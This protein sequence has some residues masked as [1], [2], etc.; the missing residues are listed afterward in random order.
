MTA[1]LHVV[2]AIANTKGGVGKTTT[3]VNLAA[4]LAAP[5]RRVLLVDLDSQG[6]ASLSCGVPRSRLRPSSAN[7][8]LNDLPP[9]QAIRPTAVPHLD[10]ITGSIELANADLVLSEVKGREQT[11]KHVLKGPRAKYD[12]VILD[13]PPNLS[14][15]GINAMVAADGVIVPVA[16]QYLA[17]EGLVTLLTA[18]EKVRT[19]LST[20]NRVLGIL[21]NLVD[22]ASKDQAE[23]RN[24]LRAQY[25]DRVFHTEIAATPALS[26]A[27]GNGHTIFAHAPRSKAADAFRRLAG[28]VLDRLHQR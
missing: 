2:I 28:E 25:R 18:L 13:T 6:S 27:P 12:I 24:R 8:L 4:A 10:L 23:L 15:V 20:R 3:A 17:L 14:L 9:D 7:V 21:L 19:R 26:E 1:Q 11:L 22:G 5:S 16:P